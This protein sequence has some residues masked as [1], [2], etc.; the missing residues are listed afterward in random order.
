MA[1]MDEARL[2]RHRVDS[3]SHSRAVYHV[4]AALLFVLDVIEQIERGDDE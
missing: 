4:G 2:R 1:E 3:D